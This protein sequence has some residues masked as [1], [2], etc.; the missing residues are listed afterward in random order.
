MVGP[1]EEVTLV[2]EPHNRHDRNAIQVLNISGQQVGHLSRNVV[3][4]LAPLIDRN[5]IA[6]EGLIFRYTFNTVY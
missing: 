2:R 6:V 5:L 4:K 1:S 3:E